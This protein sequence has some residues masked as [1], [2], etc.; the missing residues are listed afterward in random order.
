MILG[1]LD[2]AVE[3]PNWAKEMPDF[4]ECVRK[5]VLAALQKC[6]T[7]PQGRPVELSIVLADNDQVQELNR[8]YREQDKPTNVLSFP[9]LA[10]EYPGK[11]ILEPGPLHLGDIILAFG[12]VE[13]EAKALDMAFEN[14][15]IHLMVHGVLHLLGF[16]HIEDD[17]AEEMEALEIA[18]LKDFGIANPYEIE[19][20]SER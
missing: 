6:E 7:D 5:S 11:L 2:V 15:F 8:D 12:I 1:D 3:A 4:E 9:A 14:H 10:C 19:A 17:E 18:I 20:Q 13:A 16:D